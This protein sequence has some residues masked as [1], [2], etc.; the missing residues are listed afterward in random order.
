MVAEVEVLA[1][2]SLEAFARKQLMELAV[3]TYPRLV[4]ADTVT[5]AVAG[6]ADWVLQ[7][8]QGIGVVEEVDQMVQVV[9]VDTCQDHMYLALSLGIVVVY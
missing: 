8:G 3:W 4:A 1:P 6:T 2:S 7:K 9:Q 5:G